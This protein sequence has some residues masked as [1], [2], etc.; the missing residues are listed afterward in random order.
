MW[1]VWI[2]AHQASNLPVSSFHVVGEQELL[3]GLRGHPD[4]RKRTFVEAGQRVWEAGKDVEAWHEWW[5]WRSAR[6]EEVREGNAV[7]DQR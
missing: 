3:E 1:R 5:A 7:F 4:P 2:Y 6:I